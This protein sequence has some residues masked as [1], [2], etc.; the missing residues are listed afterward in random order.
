MRNV[1]PLQL[2]FDVKFETGE[3]TSYRAQIQ[4]KDGGIFLTSAGE[5][6]FDDPRLYGKQVD[7]RELMSALFAFLRGEEIFLPRDLSERRAG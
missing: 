7:L 5:P 1:G 2:E 3:T 6:D 4:R